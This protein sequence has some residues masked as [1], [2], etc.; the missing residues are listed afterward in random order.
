[1]Q[2][3]VLRVC[4]CICVCGWMERGLLTALDPIAEEGPRD[5][6]S[7]VQSIMCERPSLWVAAWAWASE[8]LWPA[9][10]QDGNRLHSGAKESLG[11]HEWNRTNR[12]M[13]FTHN[14]VFLWSKR[15]GCMGWRR[16]Q[17]PPPPLDTTDSASLF[18]CLNGERILFG[19]SPGSVIKQ[20]KQTPAFFTLESHLVVLIAGISPVT[21]WDGVIFHCFVNCNVYSL[22]GT[23]GQMCLFNL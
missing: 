11:G 4:V 17:C 22:V 21:C 13:S 16:G 1:M 9:A 18:L 2:G 3:T 5:L 23:I 10:K 14:D 19:L 20:Q 15:E 7:S 12:L 8:G 6:L